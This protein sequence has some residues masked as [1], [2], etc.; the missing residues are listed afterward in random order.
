ML[1]NCSKPCLAVGNYKLKLI[2]KRQLHDASAGFEFGGAKAGVVVDG[3]LISSF[4]PPS[5]T[6]GG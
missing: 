2:M 4:T 6:V 1:L 5:F 3:G